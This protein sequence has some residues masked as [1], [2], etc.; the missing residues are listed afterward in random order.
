MKKF[1]TKDSGKRVTFA[2]GMNRDTQDD[3]PRYDLIWTP[4]LTRLADLLVRGAVKYGENNWQK[5][6][7][8]EELLRFKASAWRHFVQYMENEVDEDHFAAVMFNM[9]GMEY[10]KEKMHENTGVHKK[11]A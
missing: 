10:V 7:T 2:T 3:K 8:E 9:I 6:R 1:K 4:A 11:K 5:A